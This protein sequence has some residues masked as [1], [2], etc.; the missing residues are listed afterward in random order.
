LGLAAAFRTNSQ[1]QD[2]WLTFK[3]DH[4]R[5]HREEVWRFK[6]FKKNVDLIDS[7]N[8]KYNPHTYFAINFFAD[9]TQSEKQQYRQGVTRSTNPASEVGALE[10]LSKD[11][12]DSVDW[13]DQG[14]VTPIGRQGQ[15][16][17]SPYWSAVTSLEGAWKIAGN[18]LVPLSV[19]QINDCSGPEGNF[20]C[21]GGFM[22]SAFQYVIDAGGIESAKDYP[23]NGS[24]VACT[25]DKSK[26]V[27][28]FRSYVNVSVDEQSFTTAISICP[29][30]TAIDG[31]DPG[32]KFYQSGIFSS[33]TCSPSPDHG[34][35]VI[36]YG[37]NSDG[38]YY[39]LKNSFGP[40]W[41]MNGYMLL[42][43]G[44]GNMCGIL[45]YA[46]YVVV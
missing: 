30:A 35:A 20:G 12:P 40:E 1:Y 22:T 7:L 36:G 26:V 31:S 42:A 9:R 44:K 18:P 43:R 11:I 17:N 3:R 32:F 34:I 23:Y 4:Q 29:V 25:F 45:T 2:L 37:Q 15:C 33:T 41:G 24:D 38:K 39:I 46:S 16:G 6:I 27:A 14:A 5:N 21:N 8:L 28:K 10:T 13:R 19:Q